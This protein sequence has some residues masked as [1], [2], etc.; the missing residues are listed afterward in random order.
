MTAGFER[1]V[2]GGAARTVAGGA[3]RDRLR[4]RLAGPFVPALADDFLVAREHRS[5]AWI[6][7][8][9][10]EPARRELQCAP[11]RGFIEGTELHLRSFFFGGSPGRSDS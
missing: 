6:R 2:R 5:D 8:R 1:D 7:L 9:A 10:V 4:V 11:H 3:H